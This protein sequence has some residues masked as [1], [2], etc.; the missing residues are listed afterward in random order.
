MRIRNDAFAKRAALIARLLN[1][2]WIL[3]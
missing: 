3:N 1:R 2:S